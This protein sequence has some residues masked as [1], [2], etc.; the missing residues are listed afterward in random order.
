MPQTEQPDLQAKFGTHVGHTHVTA[1]EFPLRGS[2]T[3]LSPTVPS[4]RKDSSVDYE[5]VS[6]NSSKHAAEMVYEECS[7]SESEF[8]LKDDLLDRLHDSMKE[9]KFDKTPFEFLPQD[10]FRDIFTNLHGGQRDELSETDTVI[11]LMGRDP[12]GASE[13][14][15]DLANYILIEAKRVFL[16]AVYIKL[17]QL[18][19]V[20]Q[21]FKSNEFKDSCLPLGEWSTE[22]MKW[23]SENHTFARMEKAMDII[24]RKGRSRKLK[25]LCSVSTISKFQKA[26]WQFLAP[27]LS[28]AEN[29][30]KFDHRVMPF[31]ERNTTPSSGA[32]GVVYKYRIHA[33]H[34]VDPDFPVCV[35]YSECFP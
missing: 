24:T 7:S 30:N 19:D 18:Y 4:K 26:Q 14:T 17:D 2:G 22:Q 31:I 8:D 23:D 9:S 34:F 29:N 6:R 12:E 27:V 33:A 1:H 10:T 11:H 5:P 16:I 35:S 15:K 21:L 3:G 32:H 28:T 13:D 20:M 25:R